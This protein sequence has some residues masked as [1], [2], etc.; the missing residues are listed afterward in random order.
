M[1]PP[2]DTGPDLTANDIKAAKVELDKEYG[3]REAAMQHEVQRVRLR[4]QTR[5]AQHT[6]DLQ[7]KQ[8]REAAR[9]R[10]ATDLAS[11]QRLAGIKPRGVPSGTW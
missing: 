6:A 8:Q 9:V 1:T 5:F 11:Q 3:E 2:C 10:R 4:D 7:E